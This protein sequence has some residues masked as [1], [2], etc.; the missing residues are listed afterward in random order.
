MATLKSLPLRSREEWASISK[1]TCQAPDFEGKVNKRNIDG[2]PIRD[3]EDK[4][5]GAKL[6]FLI[7]LITPFLLLISTFNKLLDI[8]LRRKT[9]KGMS[10]WEYSIQQR[11]KQRAMRREEQRKR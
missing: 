10:S 7:L 1:G 2:A 11:K 8:T 3:A 5:I 6:G 9:R 4:T